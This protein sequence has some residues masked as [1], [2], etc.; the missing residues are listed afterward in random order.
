VRA[1]GA[2]MQPNGKGSPTNGGA[3]LLERALQ[4]L[5]EQTTMPLDQ[6]ARALGLTPAQGEVLQA[7]LQV[8]SLCRSRI[9]FARETPWLWLT[10]KGNE[11]CGMGP[12]QCA[13]APHP[14]FLHHRRAINEVRILL[15]EREP[16]GK[17]ISERML[18]EWKTSWG[19]HVPDAIFEVGGERHAIEVELTRKSRRDY[20]PLWALATS[21]YDAVIYFAEPNDV[22]WLSNLALEGDWSKLVFRELP[23]WGRPRTHRA[24][25]AGR[26]PYEKERRVINFVAEQGMVRVDQVDRLVGVTT[27]PKNRLVEGMSEAHLV[28][29]GSVLADEPDWI[30]LTPSGN[31]FAA[32]DLCLFRPSAGAAAERAALNELRLHIA[33]Q[34]P[35]A[36]WVSHRLLVKAHGKATS[37]LPGAEVRFNGFRHAINVRTQGSAGSKSPAELVRQQTSRYDAVIFFCV[38][39]RARRF[40]ELLQ[41]EHHWTKVVI[42]DMPDPAD[43]REARRPAQIRAAEL[44]G[45]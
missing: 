15:Q 2:G 28:H 45:E 9:F 1:V 23:E 34:T 32:S 6:L 41:R 17:W 20:G 11:L 8:K 16:R 36:E 29:R 14:R 27:S 38:S 37:G 19:S 24:R 18:P 25:K 21:R 22:R 3:D 7:K 43:V 26:E 4:L 39:L 42:R 10:R 33:D 31:R 30:W 44:L 12:K 13:G 40:L 5:Y 35:E